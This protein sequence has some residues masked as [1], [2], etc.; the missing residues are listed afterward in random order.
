[1]TTTTAVD[2]NAIAELLLAA[3]RER[4]AI[5]PLTETY[6]SLSPD[7]AFAIQMAAQQTKLRRG[8]RIVG[9][10]IGLTSKVMQDWL[11]VTEPDYGHLLD[12]M[13]VSDGGTVDIA[14]LI[15]PKIEPEI[16]FVFGQDISGR[17]TTA[18]CLAA[19]RWVVPA[20]EI[21]DSRIEDWKIKLADTVS[22]NGSSA[23]FVIG[24]PPVAPEGIDLRLV[25]AVFERNGEI[26]GTAAGAAVLGQPIA[27]ATWLV[28]R[29]AQAG[30]TM[31]A[32]NVV[33]SGAL[34]GAAPLSPGDHF[35]C[36][37]DRLGSVAV[38]VR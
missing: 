31:R 22:D 38:S 20:L 37:I 2:T 18:E 19:I 16:A 32:G 1:M 23:R 30:Q 3:E 27:A 7:D 33:L 17:V 25:G 12:D 28:N 4:V 13:A 6:P 5:P 14:T 26:I 24:G 15:Q 11:K 8:A 36:S 10:K 34:T 21:I 9:W 29:L 35:R